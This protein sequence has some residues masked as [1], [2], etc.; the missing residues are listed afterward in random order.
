[1]EPLTEDSQTIAGD[2]P[3]RFR[4]K[5]RRLVVRI[6]A[7]D[8]ADGKRPSIRSTRPRFVWMTRHPEIGRRASIDPVLKESPRIRRL[9]PVNTTAL[10]GSNS[11]ILPL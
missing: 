9:V 2:W 8:K 1:M 3:G 11:L 4:E 7:A 10:L 6:V 5:K